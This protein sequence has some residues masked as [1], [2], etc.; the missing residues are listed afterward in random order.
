MTGQ[1]EGTKPMQPDILLFMSDQHAPQYMGAGLQPVDTPNLDALRRDGTEFTQA[2]TACPLCVPARMAMLSGLRASRTGV[3]TNTDT[4]PDTLPTFV[5]S[6]AAAGYETVLCGRMHFIGADQRHGFARRI[7]PDFTNSGWVRPPWLAEDFGVHTHTMGYKWCTHVVGGG[8]SPVVYYDEMVAQAAIDYLAQ[9]HE[10]PQFILVGT[11]GPHFPYVAPRPLFEKY[12]RTVQLPPDFAADAQTLGPMLR[13]LQ[14]PHA[15]REVA[16]ACNAAYKGMVEHTDA[17]VGAVRAAFDAFVQKRGTA[18]L[19]CYLSD[20]G[21]TVG[22]HGIYGKKTFFEQSVDIPLIFAGDGVAAARRWEHPVSLLDVGPTVCEWTRAE[23]PWQTDGQSL[24]GILRTGT[25]DARRA[26]L[27]EI[28]DKAPDGRWVYGC[29]VRQGA[30][31][32]IRYHGCESGDLLFDVQAD[33]RERHNLAHSRPKVYS[34]LCELL[35]QATDPAAAEALQAVHARRAAVF[36]AAEK[37]AGY[38]DRERFRAYPEGAKRAP[39]LCV[40]EL[41]GAPGPAQQSVYHGLPDLDICPPAVKK[42]REN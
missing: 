40:T 23:L 25:G 12:L 13:A 4:L 9:P 36:A 37:A 17:L 10:K 8:E 29:M 28:V 2:L 22:E 33:A 24:A 27:S 11:Y 39:E 1:R 32:L 35:A 34:A 21:D 38:D 20:H 19:F 26:V 18:K 16:L 41:A 5:H 30:Y 14:E 7:A 6:L 15:R 31:K 42:E 3:F